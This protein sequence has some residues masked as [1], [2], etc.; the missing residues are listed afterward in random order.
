MYACSY[1]FVSKE[2][3]SLRLTLPGYLYPCQDTDQRHQVK[4]SRVFFSWMCTLSNHAWVIL[5]C[6]HCVEEEMVATGMY[7]N[8]PYIRTTLAI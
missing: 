8:I 4:G 2:S 3:C 5:Q 6:I 1:I 7:G